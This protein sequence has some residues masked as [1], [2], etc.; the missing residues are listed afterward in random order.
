[1]IQYRHVV[2]HYQDVTA[3]DHVSLH[4]PPGE[5]FALL[6]ASGCG[7]TTT[8]RL[9][10]G[11]EQPDEGEITLNEH[12]VAGPGAWIPPEQRAVGMV[13]QDYAL[14]P[15]LT[16]A[17]NIGFALRGWSNQEKKRR[18]ADMLD[19]VG[20]PG[21]DKRYPHQLSGGQKQRVALARALAAR[22]SVVLLDEPFSNLDAAM[23]GTTREDV[24][25]ILQQTD[26]TA[27]FVTH[28]QEEA[29][30]IANRMAVMHAGQV[31]QIDT[32][33]AIYEHPDDPRV[34][35]FLGEV[36]CVPGEAHGERAASSLGDVP[37]RRPQHGAIELYIRPEDLTIQAADAPEATGQVIDARYYGREQMIDVRLQAGPTVRVSAPYDDE[38]PPQTPVTV[39]VR[40]PLIAFPVS[41]D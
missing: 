34:A 16:L 36:H 8:L 29:M 7:K 12:L 10:A 1:M 23:R 3:V 26:A 4:I 19:L 22:P 24:R 38:F 11:L 28:D 14:F 32:P 21:L 25:R 37:L 2:K 18:I 41:S 6:G 31:L 20:L 17:G 5:I 30:L 35:R 33:R 15:H 40:R 9:L 39:R 13:F 27:L